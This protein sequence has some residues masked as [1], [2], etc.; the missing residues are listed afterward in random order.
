MIQKQSYEMGRDLGDALAFLVSDDKSPWNKER[1]L[2]LF[3]ADF[4]HGLPKKRQQTVDKQTAE[5]AVF[6]GFGSFLTYLDGLKKED[7]A[8]KMF[9][10]Y[11]Y[12][13]VLTAI[14]LSESLGYKGQI[15]AVQSSGDFEGDPLKNALDPV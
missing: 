13:G 2:F 9:T 7:S 4:S 6:A 14:K 11:S 5:K 1:V 8:G 3:A 15:M 12:A 10:P